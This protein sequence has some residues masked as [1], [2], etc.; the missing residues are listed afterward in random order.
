MPGLKVMSGDGDGLV[1][2]LD[3]LPSAL[4]QVR[5]RDILDAWDVA[6]EAARRGAWGEARSFRFRR[7]DG[8][9]TEF[10][11]R[12]RDAKCWAAAVDR[13]RGLRTRY[14]LSI[15]LRLLALV[16]LLAREPGVAVLWRSDAREVALAP[17]LIRLAAEAPLTDDAAFDPVSLG[18]WGVGASLLRS[19]R[20]DGGG[21]CA[22]SS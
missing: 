6:R 19:G 11:L 18:A 15:C 9:W 10:A 20:F 17:A 7:G 1:Y 16:E 4:P 13:A 2:E 22:G 5:G 14:G 12:D 8:S 3:D 21:Q